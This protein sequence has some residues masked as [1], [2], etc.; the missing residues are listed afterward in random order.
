MK[1]FFNTSRVGVCC[2]RCFYQLECFSCAVALLRLLDVALLR[3]LDVALLRLLDVALLRL[4]DVFG[5]LLPIFICFHKADTFHFMVR[6]YILLY[7]LII[8]FMH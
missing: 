7:H 5:V 8:S 4:L 2:G 1:E 3:L 6:C